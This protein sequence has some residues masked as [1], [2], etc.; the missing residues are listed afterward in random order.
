VQILSAAGQSA[1]DPQVAIDPNGNAVFAWTRSDGTNLR[2]EA[3]A[4]SAPGSLSAVQ[5]LSPSG[6]DATA[7][8]LGVDSTDNAVFTWTR[9]DGAKDRVQAR[10]RSAAGTL[11]AVQT[12][13]ASGQNADAPQVAVDQSGNA[14]F[15]WQRFDGTT[16]CGGA[17]GCRRIQ[18]QSRAATGSLSAVQTLSAAGQSASEPQVGIDSIDRSVFTWTR[19]DGT[20]MRIQ[21]RARSAAGTLS[22]VQTLS[23]TGEDAVASQVAMSV[24]G[25]PVATWQ[26]FDGTTQCGGLPGCYRTQAAAGP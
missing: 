11:G 16:Q 18:T 13:S 4:R 20:N 8:Q 17:P 9:F 21:A 14:V 22:I 24:N 1:T 19:F 6:Q 7:P 10:A 2:I 12:L 5:L 3:R 26:R 15:A 23:A 25:D